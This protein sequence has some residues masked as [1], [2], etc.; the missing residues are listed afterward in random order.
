MNLIDPSDKRRR[1]AAASPVPPRGIRPRDVWTVLW[2]TITVAAGLWFLYAT[3]RIIIWVVAAA[4]FA[5]VLT[6]L[7][8]RLSRKMPKAVAV[9]AI[10]LGFLLLVG[11]GGYIFGRPLAQQTIGFVRNLP[12]T[13]KQ[14][15]RLPLVEDL[16]KRY[17]LEER[18]AKI[19]KD[20]PKRAFS[21][22]GPLLSAFRTAGNLVVAL[23][24][25]FVLT[26]FLLIYGPS[27][28]DSGLGLIGDPDKRETARETAAKVGRVFT[29]W[30]AG[31]ALTSIIAT[32]A[33]FF[34]LLIAGLP[35]A[36]LLALWVGITDLLPLIGA[37]LG[38]IPAVTIAFIHSVPAGI[39]VLIYF[40]VYQQFENHVLQPAVYGRTIRINPFVV[41][42][43]VLAGVE[44]AG[45]LGALF[46]IPT[47]GAIQ[48][49]VA[50]ATE[51]RRLRRFVP[52]DKA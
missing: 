39:G 17:D 41:L 28:V 48:I 30:L 20:L 5:T 43:S 34:T 33:S 26:I 18:V 16:T 36:G 19:S 12:E 25:I 13:I 52:A 8:T 15:Q 38:A 51:L 37:T 24:T 23:L 49:L 40:L 46:A 9:A 3:Q 32:I 2:V 44:L 47:A 4:F 7:V 14:A 29:G 1:L 45:I 11:I 31:N 35:Y 27:F 22:S 50:E 21:L 42:I 6:P 10:T